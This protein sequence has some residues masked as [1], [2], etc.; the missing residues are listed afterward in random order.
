MLYI[1]RLCRTVNYIL[2]ISTEKISAGCSIFL[3]KTSWCNNSRS[4]CYN[5]IYLQLTKICKL[6]LSG[7]FV[8]P[9]MVCI[10]FDAEKFKLWKLFMSVFEQDDKTGDMISACLV[11]LGYRTV[12][13]WF[14][15]FPLWW[16]VEI[17]LW[18]RAGTR[19][20]HVICC[21]LISEQ[22]L[23]SMVL[24]DWSNGCWKFLIILY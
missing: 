21:F 1:Y 7:E 19:V 22:L 17:L 16:R 3:I 8:V 13:V 24:C 23:F 9:S 14:I 18:L 15:L 5:L 12:S 10:G 2:F 20:L 6:K 4:F 11:M